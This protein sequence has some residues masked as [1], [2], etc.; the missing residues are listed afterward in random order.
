MPFHL[1][2]NLFFYS[3]EYFS[4]VVIKIRIFYPK[5]LKNKNCNY[6]S[7]L[8]ILSAFTCYDSHHYTINN[9]KWA[10]NNSIFNSV[11]FLKINFFNIG[12]FSCRVCQALFFCYANYYSIINNEEGVGIFCQRYKRM[13]T[14]TLLFE[15]SWLYNTPW[16][17]A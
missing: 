4:I 13:D 14:P 2:C 3:Q 10:S 9:D 12:L 17:L 5:V 16:L 8:K 15:I 11:I 7:I 1:I 6:I